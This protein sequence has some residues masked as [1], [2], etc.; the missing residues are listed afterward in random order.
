[1][2]R[3]WSEIAIVSQCLVHELVP[4]V[5]EVRSAK[6]HKRVPI[7]NIHSNKA[8]D[9]RAHVIKNTLWQV[10]FSALY[11]DIEVIN[12]IVRYIKFYKLLPFRS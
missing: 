3:V 10:Q 11:D 2:P 12:V 5:H 8:G 7:P 4:Q 6:C 1:M 9:V